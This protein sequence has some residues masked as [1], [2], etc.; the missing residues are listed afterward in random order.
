M[1]N[2]FTVGM[3]TKNNRQVYTKKEKK[4][5]QCYVFENFERYS[6]VNIYFKEKQIHF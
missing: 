1:F 2:H 6:S 4:L 5:Y 3:G